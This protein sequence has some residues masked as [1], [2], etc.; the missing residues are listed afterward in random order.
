LEGIE[1][2]QEATVRI[3]III[4]IESH[5]SFIKIEELNHKQTSTIGN[6][7]KEKKEIQKKRFLAFVFFECL[8]N[9]D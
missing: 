8:E 2:C 3:W 6:K 9:K 1:T 4:L 5:Y 7:P